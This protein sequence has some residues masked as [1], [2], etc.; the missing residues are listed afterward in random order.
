MLAHPWFTDDEPAVLPSPPPLDLN[1][2]AAV[3][4]Q[5]GA[6]ADDVQP[7]TS[8]KDIDIAAAVTN[9]LLEQVPPDTREASESSSTTSDAQHSG[10]SDD[11]TD[12]TSV[13][14]PD[15]PSSPDVSTLPLEQA[16]S[17]LD[18]GGV[19]RS[20][21]QSTLGPKHDTLRTQPAS[22]LSLAS[23]KSDST[24]FAALVEEGE[25]DDR[26][27]PIVSRS[28]SLKGKSSAPPSAF[29][30]RTPARTKRRSVSSNN[31]SAPTS[32]TEPS[33]PAG[34]CAT[35]VGPQHYASLL[36][37][38]APLL[39]TTPLE[40][41]LLSSLSAL[42]FD[43]G[44]I[45]H[46]VLTD[47]CDSNGALWWLLKKKAERR[48]VAEERR[49]AEERRKTLEALDDSSK[50]KPAAGVSNLADTSLESMFDRPSSFE[51]SA[52][53]PELASEAAPAPPL[54]KKQDD[55]QILLLTP[56]I[57]FVPPTPKV[58]TTPAPHT[59]PNQTIV[60]SSSSAT[61]GADLDGSLRSSG[62]TPSTP[63]TPKDKKNNK[64]RSSSVSMLQRAAG[65]VRKKSEEK[66]KEREEAAESSPA[67]S[68]TKLSWGRASESTVNSHSSASAPS[69]SHSK[70]FPSNN[71]LTKSPPSGKGKEK[72]VDSG[73]RV[74]SS[75]TPESPWTSVDPTRTPTQQSHASR[76]VFKLTSPS[77]LST[78]LED[79]PTESF[80]RE[81]SGDMGRGV[82]SR[83]QRASIFNTFRTWFQEDRKKAKGKGQG[84]TSATPLMQNRPLVAT[85]SSPS[86]RSRQGTYKGV[87]KR[88]SGFGH[89]K[90]PSISSRRSSS[91]NSRRSSVT[92]IPPQR[93]PSDFMVPP[94]SPD[95]LHRISR[96]RSDA[97]RR[98]MGS[99]T[100]SSEVG[101]RPSSIRSFN[102]TPRARPPRTRSPSQSSTGSSR[103]RQT[104]SPFYH[105]RLGSGSSSRVVRQ[106]HMAHG[107]SNSQTSS[108]R[109]SRHNSFD[110][111]GPSSLDLDMGI[112]AERSITPVRERKQPTTVFVAHKQNSVF[113]APSARLATHG[114]NSWKK[115]WGAE[116]PS[117]QSR[118]AHAPLE[119]FSDPGHS[120]SIRDVFTGRASL[121]PGDEDE[122]VD[123]DD[124]TP[125]FVGGLGQLPASAF[126][127]V[128]S[129]ST[130]ALPP[131]PSLR[132]NRELPPLMG[133]KSR[134]ALGARSRP[135]SA[136]APPRCLQVDNGVTR[137]VTLRV[138]PT[139]P[140][141]TPAGEPNSAA[142]ETGHLGPGPRARRQ[143]QGGRSGPAFKHAIQEEDEGEED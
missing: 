79:K 22:K 21:S 73:H 123:E 96:Q 77:F 33:F 122:W 143:I 39:F 86:I 40:R 142:I 132:S 87:K 72:E 17:M 71:K 4:S 120:G 47:A 34:I 23:R 62:S 10:A 24:A 105:R 92:S 81:V 112:V 48:E 45:V 131:S 135:T 101:S 51:L 5:D 52:E 125:A 97:S 2:T 133:A 31:I 103:A 99:R 74:Q 128:T 6:T 136:P 119:T 137:P 12:L 93:R 100:P 91:V 80:S 18:A 84:Q 88:V 13:T 78:H 53:G 59:P 55:P 124:D 29:P 61:L 115:S 82:K 85:P 134:P 25:G 15:A 127:G 114:R 90:R 130:S 28:G 9:A 113:G 41:T 27:L 19:S 36:T 104:A 7:Q 11:N 110:V 42:G 69:L 139:P 65:L 140:L 126:P 64:P 116:P 76:Q 141:L 30:T 43:T 8:P 32:P 46:S 54:I 37:V 98:S 66:V 57:S 138:S 68:S 108:T 3:P 14:T 50:R 95:S 94:L 58:E 117:W 89:S 35:P 75:L 60:S 70:S 121:D 102:R 63:G 38:Q 44:Q 109:S 49:I 106:V 129:I 56:Q 67:T 83:P 16:V 118:T 107:R 111:P 20:G 26:L 1:S